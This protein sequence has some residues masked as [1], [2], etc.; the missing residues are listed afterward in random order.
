MSLSQKIVAAVDA[1][2]G[3]SPCDVSAAEGP[4]Q[5]SLRLTAGGTVGVAFDAIDFATSARPAWTDAEL[6]AWGDRLAARVTYL[7][8]PLVV[9]EVDPVAGEVELRSLA[10]TTR[11]GLRSYYEVRLN[12]Q[13]AL[14]FARVLF[15]ENTRQ[16]RPATCQLT[17]EVLERL[18]DDLVATSA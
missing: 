13:G 15:D 12:R 8:E 9:L 7:M 4:N 17:R 16:R 1:S 5:V 3:S 2:A 18:T 10:P 14:R 6:R 11:G